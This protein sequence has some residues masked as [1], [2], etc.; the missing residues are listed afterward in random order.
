MLEDDKPR[1]FEVECTCVLG[2]WSKGM[3]LEMYS[4][5]DI[6]D[7]GLLPLYKINIANAWAGFRVCIH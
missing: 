1:F 4:K 6:K 3:Y 7:A 2:V 5:K